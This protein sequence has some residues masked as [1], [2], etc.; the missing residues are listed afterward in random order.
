MVH[1]GMRERR[2]GKGS[3]VRFVGSRFGVFCVMGFGR[4]CGIDWRIGAD[5]VAFCHTISLPYGV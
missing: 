2:L 4:E 5:I 1:L 3:S